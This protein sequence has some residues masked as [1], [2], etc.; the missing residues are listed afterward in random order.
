MPQRVSRPTCSLTAW[1]NPSP[2]PFLYPEFAAKKFDSHEAFVQN[3]VARQQEIHDLVRRNTHQAQLRQKQ[4]YDKKIKANPHNVGDAVWVF[5]HVVPKGG[6]SKLL[7]GWRGPY[8]ITDVLQDGRVYVL[9]TG[10]K[11][12]Y[13]RLKPHK[14]SPWEWTTEPTPDRD[15]A[16][17]VD[18][19]PED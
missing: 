4:Q 13:E 17:I 7:R 5:C 12:H 2:C 8:K 9:D 19:Y 18:P 11:V 1:R 16:I 10:Q 6:T 14:P 3:L 15:V